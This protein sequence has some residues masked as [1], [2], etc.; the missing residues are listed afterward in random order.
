MQM[1][2]DVEFGKLA[3]LR[4][5]DVRNTVIV[6]RDR[7]WTA[8]QFIAC[9]LDAGELAGRDTVFS[10]AETQNIDTHLPRDFFT[11]PARNLPALLSR[12]TGRGRAASRFLDTRIDWPIQSENS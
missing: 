2:P 1:L 11:K 12:V 9:P 8:E 3:P 5:H 7:N 10:S 4:L 6:E